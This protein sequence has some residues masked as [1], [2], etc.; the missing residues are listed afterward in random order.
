MSRRRNPERHYAYGGLKV[1]C[2]RGHHVADAVKQPT[3]EYVVSDPLVVIESPDGEVK[4]KGRC[5]RCDAAGAPVDLQGSWPRMKE[6]LDALER[7]P[8]RGVS[9]YDLGG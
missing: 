3:G 2:P 7:N 6:L 8:S 1:R 9:S 5:K 4:V